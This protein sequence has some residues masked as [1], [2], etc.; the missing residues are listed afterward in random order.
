MCGLQGEVHPSG[1]VEVVSIDGYGEYDR[2]E[3]GGHYW[4][5]ASSL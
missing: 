4:E 1:G 3:A 2:A 5:H